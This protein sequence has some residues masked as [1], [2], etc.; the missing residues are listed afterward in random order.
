MAAS[1]QEESEGNNGLSFRSDNLQ[2]LLLLQTLGL[3][4]PS[5]DARLLLNCLNHYFYSSSHHVALTCV[6]S[7]AL[8]F[9]SEFYSAVTVNGILTATQDLQRQL[10]D[11][12]A[13]LDLKKKSYAQVAEKAR[14]RDAELQKRQAQLK[15]QLQ[16]FQKFIYTNEEKTTRANRRASNERETS[17]IKEKEIATLKRQLSVDEIA[18]AA[19][20]SQ[21][22]DRMS[23]YGV[24][25]TPAGHYGYYA[26]EIKVYESWRRVEN[27]QKQIHFNVL[28][29]ERVASEVQPEASN[30]VA[31]YQRELEALEKEMAA[32][33][34][35]AEEA[36]RDSFNTSLQLEKVLLAVENM[37][38]TCTTA[39]PSL[40]HGRTAWEKQR[41]DIAAETGSH[42]AKEHMGSKRHKLKQE[43]TEIETTEK[44]QLQR[45]CRYSL[46]LLAAIRSFITDF[47]EIEEQLN[48]GEKKK[49]KSN[50]T[51]NMAVD[52]S[53]EGMVALVGDATLCLGDPSASIV[54]DA[55]C[56]SVVVMLTEANDSAP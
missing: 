5:D 30:K 26:K 43:K 45:R 32:L 34:A 54:S 52:K 41:R 14:Q 12:S 47:R 38:A 16:R 9:G 24:D 46:E 29:L 1:S 31:V 42:E 27:L 2:Q 18:C 13:E 50:R 55:A 10:D 20:E 11:V 44:L 8:L 51:V 53:D 3:E 7:A 19:M 6:T 28:W 35:K 25:T 56:V 23:F 22:Q 33:S 49:Q 36:S 40:Q 39:R 21:A 15:A 37:F 17:Q 48:R 4:S